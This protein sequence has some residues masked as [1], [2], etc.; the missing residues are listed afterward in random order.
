MKARSHHLRYLRSLRKDGSVTLGCSLNW[1]GYIAVEVRRRRTGR[2]SVCDVELSM[3]G[4]RHRP[5]RYDGGGV[6][7]RRNVDSDDVLS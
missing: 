4:I 5:R 2:T 3:A 7:G 1:N 6:L